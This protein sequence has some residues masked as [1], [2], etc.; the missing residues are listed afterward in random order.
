[1]FC[2]CK[3]CDSLW[4]IFKMVLDLLCNIFASTNYMIHCLIFLPSG[5]YVIC[6]EIFFVN[7]IHLIIYYISW[8]IRTALLISVVFV[9][10]VYKTHPD[11]SKPFIVRF[12]FSAETHPFV[13]LPMTPHG[14][15]ETSDVVGKNHTSC[16]HGQ[17]VDI[18]DKQGGD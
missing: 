3:L 14:C 7:L 15:W 12:L 6:C 16:A 17:G 4:N 1:M 2:L 8:I 5:N 13:S 9:F 18:M 11:E 10:F